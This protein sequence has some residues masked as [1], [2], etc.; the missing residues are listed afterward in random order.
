MARSTGRIDPSTHIAAV[1]RRRVVGRGLVACSIRSQLPN[2]RSSC[3]QQLAIAS[4]SVASA[5][6]LC[7][8]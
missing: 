1:Q 6:Q 4:L 2:P 8:H 3:G 7:H 5:H